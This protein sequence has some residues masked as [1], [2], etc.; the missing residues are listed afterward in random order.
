MGGELHELDFQFHN[1]ILLGGKHTLLMQSVEV[2][3]S[4]CAPGGC[5]AARYL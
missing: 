2:H 3:R 1:A 4:G 5:P